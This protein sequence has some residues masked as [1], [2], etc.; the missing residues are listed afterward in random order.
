MTF[1][2]NFTPEKSSGVTM[3]IG[4]TTARIQSVQEVDDHSSNL[5][6]G[7]KEDYPF[8]DIHQQLAVTFV[9]VD[10]KPGIITERFNTLGFV[11][12]DELSAKDQKRFTK[13][14]K[15]YAVD[16]KGNRLISEVRTDQA[17]SVFNGFLNTLS[18]E[19]GSSWIE[20]FG[21]KPFGSI[22]ELQIALT[23]GNVRCN[24]VVVQEEYEGKI[25]NRITKYRKVS[26]PVSVP[27][28]DE[29]EQMP[30]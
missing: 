30:I 18:F 25:R 7:R 17:R 26:T 4:E 28:A 20:K 10:G 29:D 13:G 1:L 5:S 14:A 23:K 24:I 3:P 15:G 9:R 16:K 21:G 8:K 6:G 22:Q 19:D 11:R 12:Y 2:N 27:V